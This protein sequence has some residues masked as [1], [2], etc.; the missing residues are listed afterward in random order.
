LRLATNTRGLGFYR[1]FYL[2]LQAYPLVAS[3][4]ESPAMEMI[5]NIQGFL[6]PIVSIYFHRSLDEWK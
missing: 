3:R 6:F 5:G 1:R 4:K 2:V